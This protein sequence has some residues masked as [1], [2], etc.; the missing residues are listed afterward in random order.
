MQFELLPLGLEALYKGEINTVFSF[1]PFLKVL[2]Q[3]LSEEEGTR[4]KFF[5]QAL[6]KFLA[7]PDIREPI[8]LEKIGEYRE[9]LEM[10]F[11]LLYTPIADEKQTLWAVSVP[12]VPCIVCGTDGLYGL[13]RRISSGMPK[14]G[15]PKFGPPK[16][17]KKHLNLFYTI[18]LKR[19]YNVDVSLNTE[20]VHSHM[21][22]ETGL[23]S[24]CKV[25]INIDFVEITASGPLPELPVERLAPGFFSEEN[26]AELQRLLPLS[27][28]SFTGFSV[29]SL[30]DVTAT[31]ILEE[32]KSTVLNP[33]GLAEEICYG[34]I[35]TSLKALAGNRD[36]EFGLL[37][38]FRVNGKLV[39]DDNERQHSILLKEGMAN[40]ISKQVYLDMAD[41]YITRP[42][43]LFFED[44]EA[45]DRKDYPFL[46]ALRAAGVRSFAFLP[47]FHNAT[48][49]GA[50]EIHS[51]QPHV[52]D[53]AVLARLEPAV[54]VISQLL[55]RDIEVFNA[56][57]ERVIKEKFT[58]LQQPVEWRFREAAWNYMQQES[59][60][61]KSAHLEKI[62]FRD[63]YPLYG[64]IDIRNSTVERNHALQ[65]DMQHH[66]ELLKETLMQI[67]AAHPIGLIDELLFRCNKW[68]Q[69]N[70]GY[71]SADEEMRLKDFLQFEANDFLLQLRNTTT[72]VS[73]LIDR[74]MA[75][76][77][78]LE[79]SVHTHRQELERS[80]QLINTA[81]D[82][83][84]EQAGKELQKIYPYYFEKIR[85]DGV[86]YDIYIGQ[87]ILPVKPF[88]PMYLKN[89]RLW[90]IRSMAEIARIT[91][92]LQAEM[93]RTLLTTQLI[94][95]HTSPIDI[96]FRN[97]ERRLDVEGAYNIRYQVVKKRIDKVH[98][99]NTRERLTQPG[100][101]ALVYFNKKDADEYL[102]YIHYL[103]EEKMLQD[104]LEYLELEDLQGVSGLR[105]IRVSVEMEE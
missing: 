29:I 83:Y 1:A 99:R 49:A 86:E 70:E 71:L 97:D 57:L 32:I 79:G 102:P 91:H 31:H 61:G 22:P 9:L 84:F 27:M 39:I 80:I 101:I 28:F 63:V 8:P 74:Y 73:G 40:G 20:M 105:A 50:I 15:P 66:F 51:R 11:T 34:E 55:D 76:V 62:I 26:L 41:E 82:N 90:Q 67:R 14:S 56:R 16:S 47:V 38:F 94:F 21:D 81:L 7:Y 92:R 60:P 17:K 95:V 64:A 18:L 13:V 10:L 69:R 100:K 52:L 45:L 89:L 46:N 58:S 77:D 48:L 68:L 104:D 65:Q 37:P 87:S 96:S 5:R 59:G 23:R 36:I 4:K 78:E 35:I 75:A 85:T 54:P 93:P 43:V 42:R 72:D 30:S 44:L 24:Y 2:E 25:N 19:L 88:N 6:D 33:S 12:V 98:I 53:K 103:R 3:R